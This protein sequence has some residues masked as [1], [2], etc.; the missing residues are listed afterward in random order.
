FIDGE[1]LLISF[2]RGEVE[3]LNIQSKLPSSVALCS[4][5]TRSVNEDAPHRFGGGGKKMGAP[6]ELWIFAADQPQPC[7][8]DKGCRLQRVSCGLIRH[9][10]SGELA[11]LLIDQRQQFCGGFRI[12][13]FDGRQEV[14][15]IAHKQRLWL[16]AAPRQKICDKTV[17]SGHAFTSVQVHAS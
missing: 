6:G 16:L 11:Q 3:L 17:T 8:M 14:S 2:W 4:L 12:A 9:F 15:E 7:F 10:G 13:L 1:K 5:A